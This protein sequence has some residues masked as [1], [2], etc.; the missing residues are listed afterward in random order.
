[1]YQVEYRR[2]PLKTLSAMPRPLALRIIQK[3]EG[4]CANP[5]AAAGVKK[6][7]GREGYR[8]RVGDWRVIYRIERERLVIDVITIA[9][10]QG[11]YS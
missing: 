8:L 9:P 6:L 11:A 3:I 10:R 7:A 1:M 4:L 2:D 5:F